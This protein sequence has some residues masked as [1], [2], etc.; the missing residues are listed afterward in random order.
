MLAQLGRREQLRARCYAF[1]VK[2]DGFRPAQGPSA[3]T[4]EGGR[5]G[6]LDALA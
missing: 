3:I 2:W 4:I 6:P 1:G 5:G